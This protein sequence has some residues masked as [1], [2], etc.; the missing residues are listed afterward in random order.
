MDNHLQSDYPNKNA[1]VINRGNG[2]GSGSRS[3]N[4]SSC[5]DSSV[6]GIVRGVEKD[7]N[8]TTTKVVLSIWG[9]AITRFIQ[10]I[11]D[12]EPK[13]IKTLISIFLNWR[14]N[15]Y[16]EIIREIIDEYVE[17]EIKLL[18]IAK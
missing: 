1:A 12:R 16:E 7:N 9:V 8:H 10:H 11:D 4:R 2:S 14:F 5:L 18:E 15:L 3:G 6:R 17:K 13:K